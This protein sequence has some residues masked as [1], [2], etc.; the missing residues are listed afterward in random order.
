MNILLPLVIGLPVLFFG[1]F[2]YAKYIDRLFACDD[3]RP[4][5]ANVQRDDVDFVPTHPFVLFGH[6]FASIAGG[7]PIIGPTLAILFGFVPVWLWIILGAVFLGAVHD[8]AA[9]FT[10]IREK[11]QSIAEVAGATMGR[12]VSLVM[13]AFTVIMLLMVTSVFLKLTAASLTSLVPVA[14]LETPVDN[15]PV[16]IVNDGGVDKVAIG[17]IASTSVMIVTLFAPLIGWLLYKRNTNILNTWMILLSIYTIFA[18]GIPVW[19]VLQPRDFTNVFLLYGGMGL[20]LIASLIAGIGGLS[21]NA[22]AFNL[23]QGD[24]KIGPIFPLLFITVACGAISGFHSLV[25]GGTSAKQIKKESHVRQVAYGGMLLEGLLALVVLIAVGSGVDFTHYVNIVHPD[26][27]GNPILGFALGMGGLLYKGLGINVVIGTVFGI[28]MVE[29]FVVT[30]LDTAVRLN[31]YLIEELWSLLFKQVPAIMK[32]YLFNSSLCVLAMYGLARTNTIMDLWKIFGSANQ[33]L[34]A[35]TLIAVSAWLAL[36]G[37]KFWVT[38]IPAAFM[39][40]M[41]MT[42]LVFVFFK[43]YLPKSN[44]VLMSADVLLLALSLCVLVMSIKFISQNKSGGA[45]KPAGA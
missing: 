15:L 45:P 4:T 41:T 28:L 10:S 40:V 23:A 26:K 27:G 14:A 18:A 13:L 20:M 9:L 8:M 3:N 7:G 22:P 19:L 35:L 1:Y 24:A 38:L 6:H 37:R 21:F 30:T 17:G 31:R 29:G 44:W 32:N 42:A 25:A 5:P 43:D 39:M 33:L 34:A 11:G 36:K 16:A 2:V 12:G